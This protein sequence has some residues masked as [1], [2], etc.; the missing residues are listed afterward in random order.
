MIRRPP[1][2]T[3]FPYTT[4]FRSHVAHADEPV[5]PRA[6]EHRLPG[7]PR[8]LELE[9]HHRGATDL[10]AHDQDYRGQEH[11]DGRKPPGVWNGHGARLATAR[12]RA[13]PTRP[14]IAAPPR[15]V[16]TQR[17]ASSIPA[18]RPASSTAAP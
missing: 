9:A 17:S 12:A 3:L 14:T 11:R 13:R 5:R 15:G 2:S 10:C 6:L 18:S 4:L 16:S 1:R 7:P 8:Q